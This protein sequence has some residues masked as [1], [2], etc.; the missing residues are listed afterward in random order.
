MVK[1][2]KIIVCGG[3][4]FTDYSFLKAK[5]DSFREWLQRNDD[6]DVG[7]IID[8][9][10]QGA[11]NFGHKYAVDHGILW[12][13]YPAHWKAY[14]KKAGILRN[15]LMLDQEPDYVIGFFGGV[16]TAHMVKIAKD[17][18]IPTFHVKS[19]ICSTPE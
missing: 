10:A 3:R 19:K 7:L 11:D 6:V 18:N 16:G 2:V 5:L 17:R 4:D 13:R 1:L 15:E 8:G 14:G 12:A 9:M